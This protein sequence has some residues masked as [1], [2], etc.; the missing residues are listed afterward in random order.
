MQD[1]Q[2]QTI[3]DRFVEAQQHVSD[4]YQEAVNMPLKDIRSVFLP[5]C[6]KRQD[7]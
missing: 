3:V 2:L 1:D 4:Q 6:V 7:D 5:Y